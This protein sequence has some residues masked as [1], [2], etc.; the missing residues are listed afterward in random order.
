MLP[1]FISEVF[2]ECLFTPNDTIIIVNI[3]IKVKPNATK[4]EIIEAADKAQVLSFCLGVSR[5]NGHAGW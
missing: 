3:K 1:G 2:Q 5:W 4:E